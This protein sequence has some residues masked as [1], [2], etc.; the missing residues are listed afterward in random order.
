[1]EGS[2]R[3]FSGQVADQ[4]HER[5]R[6]PA[7]AAQPGSQFGWLNLHHSATGSAYGNVMI[8]ITVVGRGRSR[9]ALFMAG[10][11]GDE[12]ESQSALPQLLQLPFLSWSKNRA[13]WVSCTWS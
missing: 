5:S 7:S 1:L 8:P 11:H 10:N 13:S 9:T 6:E 3:L 4:C 12:Y 2:S